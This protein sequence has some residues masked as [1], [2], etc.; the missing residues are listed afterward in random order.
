MHPGKRIFY[1]LVF[2]ACLVAC[3]SQT[4]KPLRVGTIPWAGYETLYLARELNYYD[5][6][7]IQLKELTSST[8]LLHGFRQGQLD[9]I[10]VTLD[11]A[12]RLAETQANVKIVLIFNISNGADKLITEPTIDSLADLQGKRIAVEQSGVGKLMLMHILKRAKLDYEDIIIVPST[13]NQHLEML[14]THQVDAA[15]TF[16]PIAQRLQQMGYNNLIDSRQFPDEIIDVLVIRDTS[17]KLHSKAI[18]QLLKGYWKARD[19]LDN[20]YQE[21]LE[22][23]APRLGITPEELNNSYQDL[24][25]PSHD[26]HQAIMEQKISAIIDS[27]SHVMMNFGLLQKPAVTSQLLMNQNRH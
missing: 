13:I 24:I 21:S 10:A 26:S 15:I 7:R 9:A 20:N 5:S 22:I 3:D 16:D 23:M 14:T 4:E 18:K 2:I 12:L 11:E 19:Y 17:L 8:E 25:L 6:H 27:M 1:L